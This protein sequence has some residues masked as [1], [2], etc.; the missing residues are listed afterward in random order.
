MNSLTKAV[1]CC[2]LPLLALGQEVR[3]DSARTYRAAE[4]VVTAT[5]SPL[6]EQDAPSPTEVLSTVQIQNANGTTVADALQYY[7]GALVRDYGAGASLSTVSLRGSASEHVLILVDGNRLSGFQ[8]GLVDFS[9]L[10][11][12]NVSRVEILHGGASAL[13]GADAVGGVINII[14]RPVSSDLRVNAGGSVG[15]YGFRRYSAS[16]QGGYEGIALL[17]GFSR[18]QGKDD[19][20][21][22][23]PGPNA[24]DTSLN[25]QD[26]DYRKNEFYLNGKVRTDEYGSIDFAVQNV[27]ADRGVPGPVTSPGDISFAREND[28]NVNAH[29]AYRDRHIAGTEVSLNTGF[30]YSF[31]TYIDPAYA[32]DS[33]YKNLL[34]NVNPQVQTVISDDDRLTIGGEFVQGILEGNDFGVRIQRT[35]TS[36]YVSNEFTVQTDRPMFDRLLLFQTL[37]YDH[38]SDVGQALTPKVG[39]NL[40]VSHDGD[41]RVRASYGQSYRAPSFNDLYYIPFNNPELHPEH[42]SSFDA[43]IVASAETFGKHRVELTYFSVSTRDRIVFDPMSFIPVNIGKTVS[44]GIESSYSGVYFGGLVD[45]GL[46][47]S[48]TDARKRNSASATDPTYDKRL[49]FIPSNLFKANVALNFAPC[50][51]NLFRIYAG[52]RP[53]NEDNSILLPSYSLTSAN[54]EA[55]MSLGSVKVS[56]KVEADNILNVRY[57]VYPGY[58]MPGTTYRFDLG[59]E[60]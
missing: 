40:R 12:D 39:M 21:F 54:V 52:E 37:R 15:S 14:T 58:P 60:Y 16:A 43:G 5:R 29:L 35:Q 10:P 9:L 47:Y 50:S 56:A 7:T 49:V 46:S 38:C 17:A 57:Q 13:Y 28:K 8:N 20:P 30:Q 31:E 55:V 27:V 4:V 24:Q 45:V 11:T 2:T 42:S 3:I 33:F 36:G 53:V 34:I 32:M 26:A 22:F 23:L 6:L 25:R 1:L 18:E 41:I 19:Y 44:H 48:Y 51:I 59:V